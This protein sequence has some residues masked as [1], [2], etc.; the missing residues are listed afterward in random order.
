[1]LL[2]GLRVML[3]GVGAV[4]IFL[5]LLVAALWLLT[6]CVGLWERGRPPDQGSSSDPAGAETVVAAAV[7]AVVARRR[8][9]A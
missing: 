9:Q 1:M 3:V 4:F 2:E 7:A 8:K 6:R 5:G